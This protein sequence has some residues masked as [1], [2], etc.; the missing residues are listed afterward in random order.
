MEQ[1]LEQLKQL[2][3]DV[4]A[5]IAEAQAASTAGNT[6]EAEAKLNE[7]KA[8]QKLVEAKQKEI[9]IERMKQ[10]AKE[11]SEK[12][13]KEIEDSKQ[14]VNRLPV[15]TDAKTVAAVAARRKSRLFADNETAYKAGKFYASLLSPSETVR[16]DAKAYCESK[17]VNYK[18]LVSAVDGSAGLFVLPEIETAIVKML[19]EYGLARRKFR[20][21]PMGSET[22]Q[23]WKEATGNTAY[24]VNAIGS[25]TRTDATWMVH[26]L[27]AKKIAAMTKYSEDL[28][29]DAAID[30]AVEITENLSRSLQ[31]K[32]DE[33][34]FTGNGSSTSGG[35]IGVT[36]IHRSILTAGSGTWAT[37][38]DKTNLASLALATGATW[39]SIT[40]ADLVKLQAKVKGTNNE[41]YGTDTLY[42]EVIQPLIYAA[43][44]LTANEIVNG[45][46]ATLFGR[47]FNFVDSM[48]HSSANNQ[49]CLAY[50]DLQLAGA[51][52][53]RAGIQIRTDSS[54][55]NFENDTVDVKATA[56]MDA[57]IHEA[58]NYNATAALRKRGA[59][60]VLVT[61]NS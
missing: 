61:K 11:L 53:D 58:G 41:F 15:A 28:S 55:T 38:A 46:G 1:L 19:D 47:P 10:S 43:G 8:K 45:V 51:F 48:P 29:E 49:V 31:K 16:N 35:I 3:A 34:C 4:E 7:A 40:L 57:I 32:E 44:G 2:V 37:D 56:R 21:F 23:I 30:L 22:R 26:T 18:T 36:E 54:G 60:A 12:T 20:V 27:T 39:G 14:A 6:A 59:L 52:G 5:M 33:V 9:E 42:Y 17:G 50:G 13:A 24:F 25:P